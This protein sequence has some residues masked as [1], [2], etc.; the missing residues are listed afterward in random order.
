LLPLLAA[1]L[2][3][4]YP[5]PAAAVPTV[6]VREFE[7]GNTVILAVGSTI[8]VE[9]VLD[10]DGL[11]FEGYVYDVSFTSNTV[12][13]ISF[14]TESY[15]PFVSLSP[16]LIVDDGIED[17]NQASFPPDFLPAGIYIL[18]TVSFKVDFIPSG[19][20]NIDAFLG[21]GDFFSLDDGNGPQPTFFGALVIPEP[22]PA[23]LVAAGLALLSLPSRRQRG[24]YGGSSS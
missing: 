22:N 8:K 15:D 18:N 5:S 23:L 19:G 1:A 21:T 20:I 4:G 10:T 13:G 14:E 16:P 12:S 7:T 2:M 3:L 24:G 9:I 17:L 6:T 11:T